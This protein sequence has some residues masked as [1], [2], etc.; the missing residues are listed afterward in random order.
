[1]FLYHERT[2]LLSVQF[3][4]D[5]T[6]EMKKTCCLVICR[7]GRGKLICI[8]S[9]TKQREPSS[10]STKGKPDLIPANM[11]AFLLM[12]WTL[13]KHIC[14]ALACATRSAQIRLV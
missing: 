8:T 6:A 13:Q 7:N 1:M 12:V 9:S 10:E 11:L 4:Q 2:V 14:L 5:G 3:A